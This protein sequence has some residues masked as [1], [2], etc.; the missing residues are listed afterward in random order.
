MLDALNSGEGGV[1][2]GLSE[3]ANFE[4]TLLKAVEQSRTRAIDSLIKEI[5]ALADSVPAGESKKK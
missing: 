3:R 5:S 1:K 2:F 4:V